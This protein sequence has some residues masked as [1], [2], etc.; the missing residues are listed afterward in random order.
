MERCSVCKARLKQDT[1]ICPR[2]KIDLSI[3]LNIEEQAEELC[4]QSVHFLKQGEMSLAAQAVEQSLQLKRD[5][6]ALALR[7]FIQSISI[8]N[9][10]L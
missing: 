9:K 8:D 4:Y 10:S 1:S 5:S 2:C 3:P 7:G 6:L